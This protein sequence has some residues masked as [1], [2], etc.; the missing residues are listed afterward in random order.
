[1]RKHAPNI[2]AFILTSRSPGKLM[3]KKSESVNISRANPDHCF[4]IFPTCFP[5]SVINL[6]STAPQM[7]NVQ[8]GP[9]IF[10]TVSPASFL[11][12]NDGEKILQSCSTVPITFPGGE[13]TS[14][15]CRQ[16]GQQQLSHRRGRERWMTSWWWASVICSSNGRAGPQQLRVQQSLSSTAQNTF[17]PMLFLIVYLLLVSNPM[18]ASS[19]STFC[20]TKRL[21]IVVKYSKPGGQFGMRTCCCGNG[22]QLSTMGWPPIGGCG[23]IGCWSMTGGYPGWDGGG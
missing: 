14:K 2:T 18:K 19:S 5:S 16:H 1:M 7:L 6:N 11:I 13:L 23:Y 3:P 20:L 15:T 22:I 10:N 8:H 17:C 4:E 21:S 9:S 12:L